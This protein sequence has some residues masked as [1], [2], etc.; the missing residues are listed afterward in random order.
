MDS[1]AVIYYRFSIS[2]NAVSCVIW[3]RLIYMCKC[4][5]K[6]VPLS[7]SPCTSGQDHLGDSCRCVSI[8]HF[9]FKFLLE[10]S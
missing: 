7:F 2:K 10:Y 5:F 6:L 3:D 9:F 4:K 1:L 8:H